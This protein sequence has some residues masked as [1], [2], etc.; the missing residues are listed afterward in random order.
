MA[1]ARDPAP[2]PRP[3]AAPAGRR[4]RRFRRAG[5]RD[6]FCPCGE[7]APQIAGLCRACYRGKALSKRRFGGNREAAIR[8]DGRRCRACGREN[9][10][11]RW[12]HLHHR[13]RGRSDEDSLVTL[14]ARCHPRVHRL[15]R[16]R[17]WMPDF[18]VELWREQHPASPLQLQFALLPL[19]PPIGAREQAA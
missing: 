18:F 11:G 5:Q 8:R 12:L 7:A 1:P 9:L 4:R 13:E 19:L 16:L 3:A 17:V 2:S 15:L 14:C 6:L 10:F